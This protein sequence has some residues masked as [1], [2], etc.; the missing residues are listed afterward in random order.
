MNIANLLFE[1]IAHIEVIAATPEP[2]GSKTAERCAAE[3]V[4]AANDPDAVIS[5][6][7]SIRTGV[8]FQSGFPWSVA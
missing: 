5:G 7:A 6:V 1:M 8:V 4:V 2:S 3:P